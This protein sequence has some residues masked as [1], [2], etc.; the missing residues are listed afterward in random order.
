LEPTAA[1]PAA[2]WNC[3][4]SD[5]FGHHTVPLCLVETAPRGLP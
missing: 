4:N 3:C 1:Q 5:L 2:I